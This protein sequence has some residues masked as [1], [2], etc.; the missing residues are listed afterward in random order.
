M[1]SQGFSL[2]ELR[3]LY[4]DEF[5]EYAQAI[6]YVLEQKGEMKEG[7]S[8]RLTGSDNTVSQLRKQIL[9]FNRPAN[10]PKGRTTRL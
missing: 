4:L 2:L 7:A 6:V 9:K 8:D 5:F 1:V 3:K 10:G